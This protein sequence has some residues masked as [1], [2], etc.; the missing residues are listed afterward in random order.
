MKTLRE[1]GVPVEIDLPIDIPTPDGKGIA[2]TVRYKIKA[3]KDAETGEIYLN[4]ET[5]EEIDRIKARRMGLLLPNQIKELRLK[6]NMT[7]DEI[8]GLL[9]LGEKTYSLW[10]TGRGRP[11]QSMNLMLRLI[12]EGR[13]SVVDLIAAKEPKF[14][15]TATF[16]PYHRPS[17]DK[18]VIYQI[19]MEEPSYD[20]PEPLASAA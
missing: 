16:T 12:W 17:P 7:Q 10:E 8:S 15:W 19:E 11:S 13:L 9:K 5:L 4:G 2:E 18:P 3:L 20:E 1:R 6:L 14:D